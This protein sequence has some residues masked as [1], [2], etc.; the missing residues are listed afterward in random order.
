MTERQKRLLQ[1]IIESYIESGEAVGSKTLIQR[2]KL[3][4]SSATVR[5]EMAVLENSGFLN[6]SHTSSGRIPSQKGYQYFA[7]KLTENKNQNLKTQLEDI[8]S[9]RRV[10][11]DLTLDEAVKAITKIVGLTL[12]TSNSTDIELMKSIQLT[13]LNPKL[14]AIVIVTSTGRVKSK[15]IE[16]N[17]MVSISN[18]RIAVRIF[19]ERL[20]DTQLKELS[21]K[22]KTLAPI[23]K[24]LV[25]NYEEL[26]KAFVSK[27]FNFD[28][29]LKNKIYGNKN[30]I[31]SNI[32]RE[33]LVKLIDLI[34]NKSI[35]ETIEGKIDDDENIKI[36]IRK[37][38]ISILSKRIQLPEN[39]STDVSIIGS[40]RMNYSEAKQAIKL[41]EQF[42]NK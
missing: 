28:H 27:I 10:S 11:I 25:K 26:I 7:K 2:Y 18:V 14:G 16:F 9:K 17:S 36:D 15:L 6:K 19:K 42:L 37:N 23:L 5:N 8:F 12:V 40:N 30:I 39:R 21:L 24:K 31:E 3:S 1:F 33:E 38:N 29:D 41:L 34:E 20:V 35:W 13:P 4:I 22:V 32:P